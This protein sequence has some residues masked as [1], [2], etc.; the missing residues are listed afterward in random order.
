LGRKIVC[1]LRKRKKKQS[2]SKTHILKFLEKIQ[3]YQNKQNQHEKGCPKST[4]NTRN[5]RIYTEATNTN[6]SI[7][8]IIGNIKIRVFR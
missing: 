1:D 6:F 5:R 2:N 7:L 4:Q 8:L 3:K